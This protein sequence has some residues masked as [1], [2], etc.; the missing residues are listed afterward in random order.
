CNGCD[1]RIRQEWIVEVNLK[2]GGVCISALQVRFPEQKSKSSDTDD[3]NDDLQ[4]YRRASFHI[5]SIVSPYLSTFNRCLSNRE[6]V[7]GL[8]LRGSV[9]VAMHLVLSPR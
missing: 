7:A 1:V 9:G 6:V 8:R 4:K 2:E 5:G 3:H